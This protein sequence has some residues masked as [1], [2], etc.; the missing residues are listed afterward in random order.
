MSSTTQKRI[1]I[2]G[3]DTDAGKTVATCALIRQLQQAE[4]SVMAVKPVA[5]GC[6][7]I[8]GQLKN[9]DALQM[10]YHLQQ[11]TDYSKINPIALEAAIAPHIAAQEEALSLTVEQLSRICQLEQF[12]SDFVLVE[13]A[14]GWLVP[15][16]SEQTYAD[17][18]VVEN[19]DVVLVVGMKLGCINHALL[20]LE[21]IKSRGLKLVGWIANSV[22]PEMN[23]YQQNI[24]FLKSTIDAPML[25][26]IP[27]I[28]TSEKP[29]AQLSDSQIVQTA[30]SYV[31]ISA[32]I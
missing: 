11:P 26:E 24:E 29:T 22:E 28:N 27:Y 6:E 25:G 18:V 5:A 8:D 20:T 23:R 4:Q 21:S 32:L 30:S 12:D 2:T 9:T 31:N 14:G 10:Q 1:F 15:L 19:L 7:L 3:T 16:N 13:G 17:F